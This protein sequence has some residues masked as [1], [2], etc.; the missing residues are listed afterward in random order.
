MIRRLLDVILTGILLVLTS[1]VILAAAL[2]IFV[3]SPGSVLFR[4]TR[5]GLHGRT[6]TMFKLRTMRVSHASGGSVITAKHDPRL[7]PLARWMRRFKL[8]ELPQL[9]NILKGDM[10]I[11]GPRARHPRI[12]NRYRTHSQRETLEVLPGLTSPGSIYALTHGEDILD[13]DDPET[14]YLRRVLPTKL[15]LDVVYVREASLAYD[16]RIIFRTMGVILNLWGVRSEPP[17]LEKARDFIE[18]VDV[19]GC[20]QEHDQAT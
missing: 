11:V 1:P 13:S 6:F 8:D 19:P 16:L 4:P 9:I 18:P 15:A 2:V 17:E 7:I 3:V 14:V 12:V 20:E 10:A 5:V